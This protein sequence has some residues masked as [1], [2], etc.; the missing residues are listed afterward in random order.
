[1]KFSFLVICFCCFGIYLV[2]GWGGVHTV[3][4]DQSAMSHISYN[5]DFSCIKNTD[6]GVC[7]SCGGQAKCDNVSGCTSYS[8]L[9]TGGIG[10][11]YSTLYVGCLGTSFCVAPS[12]GVLM[13][14]TDGSTVGFIKYVS[15]FNDE[16]C[17]LKLDPTDC[18][19]WEMTA[20]TYYN[21]PFCRCAA[22]GITSGDLM[23]SDSNPCEACETSYYMESGKCTKC[24]ISEDEIQ[25]TSSAPN[26]GGITNCYIK[27]GTSFSN[28]TGSG[29]YTGNSYWCE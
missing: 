9:T 15:A 24:P 28:D 11:P 13:A 29:T 19:N 3:T 16:T 22:D 2:P 12:N 10:Q 1:M 7:Y 23:Y 4:P 27:Y 5:S 6:T 17:L 20:T 14:E 18:G 8:N 26:L 21:F 25:G